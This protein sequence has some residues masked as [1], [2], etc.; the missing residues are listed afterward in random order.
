MPNMVE[1]LAPQLS[2]L[3]QEHASELL[4]LEKGA[5]EAYAHTLVDMSHEVGADKLLEL[6]TD[7]REASGE[8]LLALGIVPSAAST[9]ISWGLRALV[10]QRRARENAEAYPELIDDPLSNTPGGA[11]SRLDILDRH[12]GEEIDSILGLNTN[13]GPHRA[14]S[15]LKTIDRLY[16]QPTGAQI[17][18]MVRGARN[19]NGELATATLVQIGRLLRA[20][21]TYLY[22][23]VRELAAASPNRILGMALMALQGVGSRPDAAHRLPYA[24]VSEKTFTILM[25]VKLHTNPTARNTAYLARLR[26]LL[27][28]LDSDPRQAPITV[29]GFKPDPLTNALPMP[30][31]HSGATATAMQTRLKQAR[32][33]QSLYGRVAS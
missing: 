21:A 4:N 27:S 26:A 32:Y 14:Q 28:S 10:E 13:L 1:F 18:A 23:G 30:D 2:C 19:Q 8:T 9:S 17:S 33:L 20:E 31:R 25:G 7:M 5:P 22:V 11:R 29:P 3:T 16:D 15:T 6:A 24:H 12:L